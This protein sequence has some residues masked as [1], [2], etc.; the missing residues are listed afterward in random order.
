M[1]LNLSLNDIL[2][3]LG[4]EESLEVPEKLETFLIGNLRERVVWLIGTNDWME[5]CVTVVE[6]VV[7]HVL[8]H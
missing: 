3:I 1:G 2:D 4:A 6:A 8:V 5:R 7:D